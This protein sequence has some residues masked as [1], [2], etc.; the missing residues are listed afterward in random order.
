MKLNYNANQVKE[1]IKSIIVQVLRS[2]AK[3]L[4]SGVYRAGAWEHTA[5]QLERRWA[6]G[7]SVLSV[8][9]LSPSAAQNWEGGEK[10]P[11]VAAMACVP[12]NVPCSLMWTTSRSNRVAKGCLFHGYMKSNH[13]TLVVH[14]MRDREGSITLH[15]TKG[16]SFLGKALPSGLFFSL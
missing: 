10:D 2:L 6:K 12:P 13:T 7:A 5:Y 11:G 4:E 14:M 16:V 9:R 3:D 15:L 8:H 1:N